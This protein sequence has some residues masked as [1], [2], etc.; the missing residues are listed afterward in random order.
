[1]GATVSTMNTRLAGV[2]KGLLDAHGIPSTRHDEEVHIPQTGAGLVLRVVED[3][4]PGYALMQ[5]EATLPSGSRVSDRWAGLGQTLPEAANDGIIAFCHGGFHVLLAAC[6]G[7][8]ETDQVDHDLITVGGQ[9]W[10]VYSGGWVNRSGKDAHL[11]MG[12]IWPGVLEVLQSS[13]SGE[14][15]VGRL[16]VCAL[17]S[18]LTYEHLLDGE[19]HDGLGR[20]LRSAALDHSARGYASMRLFFIARH[21]TGGVPGHQRE[22]LCE[23]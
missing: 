5:I 12:A 9:V 19:P 16:F 20:V 18:R 1:M 4:T 21:R 2:L 3:A 11:T 6:G 10:D 14:I 23:M 7:L 8:L 15:H 22:S 17:D 13:V